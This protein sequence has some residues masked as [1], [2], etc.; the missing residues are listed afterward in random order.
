MRLNGG[1][2]LVITKL[3]VFDETEKIRI[4]TG[5]RYNGQMLSVVPANIEVLQQCEPV[6]EEFD[7]W[8]ESTR[9]ARSFLDLPER[10]QEYIK[11]LEGF[12][13]TKV[14]AISVGSDREETIMIENPFR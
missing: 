8:L 2:G 3:D 12:T 10:A 11:R 14:V 9:E 6:Y 13:R 4:C 5:Y 1:S 7:G